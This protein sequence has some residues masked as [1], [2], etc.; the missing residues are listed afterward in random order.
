M[1]D[2]DISTVTF[3]DAPLTLAGISFAVPQG[4]VRETTGGSSSIVGVTRKAQF[5]LPKADYGAEDAIVAITHFPGMRGM[6][7]ANLRRWLAAFTQ[8]DGR[9]S[10]EVAT[11]ARFELGQVVVTLI[12]VGGTMFSGQQMT[13]GG[14]TLENYRMLAAIVD[15]PAG[16]H[17]VKITGPAVVIEHW[18]PS[19]VAFLKSVKVNP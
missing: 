19:A 9:P 13:G 1:E 10:A 6:D 8:P 11:K 12:D 14:D 17:F 4:W 7:E 18:K 15:H 3:N 2:I 5:R 16:P